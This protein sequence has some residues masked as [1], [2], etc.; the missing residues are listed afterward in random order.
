MLP[1]LPKDKREIKIEVAHV[2][3]FKYLLCCF[4]REK[5]IALIEFEGAE[6]MAL[7]SWERDNNYIMDL[8]IC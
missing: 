1:P 2:P 4:A 5:M 7:N 6:E 3:G 8:I